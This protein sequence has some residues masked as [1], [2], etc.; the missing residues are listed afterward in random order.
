MTTSSP[1]STTP[2]EIVFEGYTQSELDDLIN[3]WQLNTRSGQL[4][5]E[6]Q[7]LDRMLG[8]VNENTNSSYDLT[9]LVI[10]CSYDLVPCD[11]EK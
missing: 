2:E 3:K 4:A 8:I 7:A 1:G 9:E 10:S 5:L 11:Y 6:S